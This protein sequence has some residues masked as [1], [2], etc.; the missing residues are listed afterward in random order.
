MI[1]E[2]FTN[3]QC[4]A[5]VYTKDPGVAFDEFEIKNFLVAN[6][7]QGEEWRESAKPNGPDFLHD[8]PKAWSG[9]ATRGKEQSP[10]SQ[11][12]DSCGDRVGQP[13]EEIAKER[14]TNALFLLPL[15]Q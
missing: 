2:T 4:D 10:I 11:D 1:Y 8:R 7:V 14:Q 13:L 15:G 6:A 12:R 3:G 9:L 5:I